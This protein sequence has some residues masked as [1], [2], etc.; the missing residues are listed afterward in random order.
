MRHAMLI[1]ALLVLP[2]PAL[3][4]QA[5]VPATLSLADAI[6]IARQNNPTYRQAQNDRAPAAWGVRNAWS[7]LLLPSLTAGGGVTYTGPGEQTFLSSSFQQ[8][9]ATIASYYDLSLN[10]QLSGTTLSQ[11]GLAK[12]QQ[13]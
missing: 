6:T 4:Q 2:T 13:R 12:A 11:P 5:G 3:A 8:D 7:S 9:V 10:W 1:A